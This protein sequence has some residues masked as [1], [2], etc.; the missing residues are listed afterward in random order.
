MYHFFSESIDPRRVATNAIF[1]LA[2]I[3]LGEHDEEE[4]PYL[5]ESLLALTLLSGDSGAVE[6]AI[7]YIKESLLMGSNADDEAANEE[8]GDE[9][10]GA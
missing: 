6:W 9:A 5:R 10:E 1:P 4:S 7:I 8:V 2:R 3:E